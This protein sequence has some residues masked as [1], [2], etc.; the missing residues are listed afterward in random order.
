M[1]WLSKL[2]G[3]IQSGVDSVKGEWDKFQRQDDVRAMLAAM[4]LVAG[5]DNNIEKSEKEAGLTFLSKGNVFK[6][7]DRK[8]LYD[9]MN[10]FYEKATND[11]LREDLY[12]EIE[13]VADEPETRVAVIKTAISMASADGSIGDDEK[14]II[15]E[16]CNRLGE[17]ARKFPK[18]AA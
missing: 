10:E 17:D 14:V 9:T 12:A 15:R 8:Y 6:G 11:F 3:T 2:T 13:G 1:G 5:A 4:A 7:F 18:I 16:I